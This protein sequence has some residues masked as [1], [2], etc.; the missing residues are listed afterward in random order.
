MLVIDKPAGL[1]VHPGPKGGVTLRDY[2]ESLRFGLPRPPELAHRLDKD[3]SGCLVLGRHAR[4]LARLG[5]LFGAGRVEKTY[6]GVVEGGP[7][8]AA[9]DIDMP[10]SRR[11]KTRGWWMKADA[12]GQPA[13]TLWRVLARGAEH[14]VLELQPLTG[15]THQLRV[16]LAESGWPLIGD[17]VYGRAPRSGPLRLMLHARTVSVP[18][19]PNRPP[20]VATAPVPAD[21]L[22]FMAAPLR[23]ISGTASGFSISGSKPEQSGL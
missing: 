11:A 4:A 10:L 5:A 2:L 14:T 13:R 8:E 20:V 18:L 16:H 6:I 9:G 23:G 21:M 7:L 15:R 1:P 19:Y 12:S 17:A 22:G 3:T